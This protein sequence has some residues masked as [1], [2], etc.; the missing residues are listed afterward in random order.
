[1]VIEHSPKSP[2]EQLLGEVETRIVGMQYHEAEVAPGEQ[3][4][5]ER[6]PENSHDECSILVEN[7]HFRP[8]GRLPRRLASWLAPLI[9]AGKLRVDGHASKTAE[10]RHNA[11]PVTLTVFLCEKGRHLLEK[12]AISGK[13]DALHE[14]VRRVDGTLS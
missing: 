11:C 10:P 7:G 8:V 3:I 2:N 4:N 12:T 6:E 13:L 9:D 14:I 5:L 1:M